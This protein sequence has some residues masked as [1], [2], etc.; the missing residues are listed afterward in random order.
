MYCLRCK[1]GYDVLP[2]HLKRACM[3]DSMPEEQDAE[4]KRA[5]LSQR[6]DEG[7]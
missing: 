7:W 3:K 2:I 5:K 6:V 4:V 1:K